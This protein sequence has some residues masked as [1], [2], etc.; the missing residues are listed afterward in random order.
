M[1]A[2]KAGGLRDRTYDTALETVPGSAQ[3]NLLLLG[4]FLWRHSFS[5]KWPGLERWLEGWREQNSGKGEV[6]SRAGR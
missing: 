3:E 2:P 4:L 1:Q 6:Q 5:G